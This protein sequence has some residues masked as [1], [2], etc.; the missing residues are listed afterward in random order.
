M[1]AF[2]EQ[3]LSKFKISHNAE[4]KKQNKARTH[5]QTKSLSR[6]HKF[7]RHMLLVKLLPKTP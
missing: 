5:K 4:L 2:T 3:C 6:V 1:G 7:K